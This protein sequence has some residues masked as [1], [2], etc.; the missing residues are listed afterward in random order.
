MSDPDVDPA[1]RAEYSSA[2]ILPYTFDDDG[3]DY[4]GEGPPRKTRERGPLIVLCD[5]NDSELQI[6]VTQHELTLIIALFCYVDLDDSEDS[7]KPFLDF[8]DDRTLHWERRAKSY[9]GSGARLDL[10]TIGEIACTQRY[11]DKE[12]HKSEAARM[13]FIDPECS[14]YELNPA[15]HDEGFSSARSVVQF[16]DRREQRVRSDPTFWMDEIRR[17][18]RYWYECRGRMRL[19]CEFLLPLL[20][21]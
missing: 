8:E 10:S 4:Q 15:I 18:W 12:T 6:D 19:S 16:I 1:V 17:T 14:A 13:L 11:A 5:K 7:N 2:S 9:R 3:V 21:S 20:Q